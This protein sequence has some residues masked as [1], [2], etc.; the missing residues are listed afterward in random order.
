MS[1]FSGKTIVNTELAVTPMFD[2]TPNRRKQALTEAILAGT[3]IVEATTR[4]VTGGVQNSIKDVLA[5]SKTPDYVYG[6]PTITASTDAL[7]YPISL[8]STLSDML[9]PQTPNNVLTKSVK[10]LSYDYI[11]A[12]TLN[13]DVNLLYS[14]MN[15]FMYYSIAIA[16]S[17]SY[18][19]HWNGD[20]ITYNGYPVI[21]THNKFVDSGNTYFH[22]EATANGV[23]IHT[24]NY[25]TDPT[26]TVDMIPISSG[27]VF[28]YPHVH[29]GKYTKTYT[30]TSGAN[31]NTL[32]TYTQY[33]YYT[34]ALGGIS[35]LNRIDKVVFEKS[36]YPVIPIRYNNS[37]ISAIGGN[38]FK[39][40][41]NILKKMNISVTDIENA[42]NS[43]PDI[44]YVRDANIMF[45]ISTEGTSNGEI[46]ALG[47]TLK[48]L[49][50][51]SLYTNPSSNE[52]NEIIINEGNFIYTIRYKYITSELIPS[53]QLFKGIYNN[54][55][56]EIVDGGTWEYVDSGDGNWNQVY[57]PK[58][59]TDTVLLVDIPLGIAGFEGYSNR[60]QMHG[61]VVSYNIQVGNTVHTKSYEVGGNSEVLLPLLDD[62]LTEIPAKYRDDVIYKSMHLVINA[63]QYS[64]LAWY[65]RG[66]FKVVL[67]SIAVALVIVNPALVTLYTTIMA[68]GTAALIALATTIGTYLITSSVTEWLVE[69]YNKLG[70]LLAIAFNVLMT[71]NISNVT[72]NIVD[73]LHKIY[74]ATID[75][76]KVY[77]QNAYSKVI[78]L[79]DS[80]D[81]KYKEKLAKVEELQDQL[82]NGIPIDLLSVYSISRP[83]KLIQNETPEEFYNRTSATLD[84]P[85]LTNSMVTNYYEAQLQLPK[86]TNTNE[87]GN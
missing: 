8:I 62:I 31:T 42:V 68:G 47:N 13:A 32:N 7:S 21:I 15:Y 52:I 26:A 17:S 87:G 48:H 77:Q 55:Q 28:K 50:D 66:W 16:D 57:V 44:A 18:G 69:K 83:S 56:V 23:V 22:S 45:G 33:F 85:M 43:S 20:T 38:E 40:V 49:K 2:K 80:F 11:S 5:Y 6:S 1:L 53:G 58:Y 59:Y 63:V 70:V 30:Y 34:E 82:N 54:G 3:S 74:T 65:Q 86:F 46:Y 81:V 84:L 36:L 41:N 27:G 29:I 72:T 19:V 24:R 4:S 39:S 51:N 76:V 79:T 73:T 60:Y 71:G 78:E 37:T 25:N 10:I 61:L 64:K 67:S 35:F 12:E 75:V 9:D 14:V